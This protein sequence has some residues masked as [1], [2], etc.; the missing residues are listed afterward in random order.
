[1]YVSVCVC[2]CV[3]V[4][5]HAGGVCVCACAFVCEF[6]SLRVF[7]LACGRVHNCARVC[8]HMSY[9]LVWT[10]VY[11]YVTPMTYVWR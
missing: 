9:T 4:C 11:A 8:L 6:V 7:A 2:V 1:M 10:D 3:C 5:V